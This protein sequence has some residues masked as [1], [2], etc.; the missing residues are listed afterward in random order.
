MVGLFR[1]IS[2]ARALE[3]KSSVWRVAWA[4]RE[5]GMVLEMVLWEALKLARLIR[6]AKES[7][8]MVRWFPDTSLD[9]SFA[10]PFEEQS[11]RRRD[12]QSD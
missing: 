1:V 11:R 2:P 4:R 5:G 10:C 6:V 12:V 8:R 7:G 9:I 3:D